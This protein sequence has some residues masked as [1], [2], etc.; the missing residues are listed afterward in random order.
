MFSKR[1]ARLE[2][3]S[4]GELYQY[5][6]LPA[7]FRVQVAHIWRDALGGYLT[8]NE[9]SEF[10]VSPANEWWRYLKSTLCRELGVFRL[11]EHCSN[12]REQC[13]GFLLQ[14]DT[15][16]ALDII[17]LSF[18]IIDR[19]IRQFDS[20]M[21]TSAKIVQSADD[22]IDE[23]NARFREH[24]LGYRYTDGI[25]VRIDSEFIHE[26]SVRPAISLLREAGFE[27]PSEEFMCAFGHYRRGDNKPAIFEALKAFESTV[28][29]IC[30]ARSWHHS[31][32]ATAAPLIGLLFEKGIIPTEM[33]SHFTAL[34]SLMESG[35]P[36]V[37]NRTSRHGQGAVPVQVPDHV[38]AYALHLAAVNIVFLVQSHK[39]LGKA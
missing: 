31:P 10:F 13:E 16:G 12:A 26:E 9:Y 23:L 39:I 33:Q 3:A 18:R 28:K 20:A 29:A 22:A 27:G 6:S 14:A 34:R 25:L 1:R 4:N 2:N 5:D 11:A 35:L 21:L 38:A 37:S 30:K 7:R 24:G 17:E 15:S 36:T 32:T 19:G 8:G